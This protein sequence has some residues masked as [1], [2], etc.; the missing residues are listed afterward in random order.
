MLDIRDNLRDDERRQREEAR[1][2][3][4]QEQIDELRLL[5]REGNSRHGKVEEAQAALGEQI[6]GI[7]AR[8][9]G[10][11]HRSAWL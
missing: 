9:E 6:E 10:R 7:G 5:L 1:L 3:A 8:I 2:N 11:S 4:L